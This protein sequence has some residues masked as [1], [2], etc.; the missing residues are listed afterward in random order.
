MC[1][2]LCVGSD[3]SVYV[4]DSRGSVWRSSLQTGVNNANDAN[5]KSNS[6]TPEPRQVLPTRYPTTRRSPS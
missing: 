2:A 5:A 1:T 4:G 6:Y 3:G